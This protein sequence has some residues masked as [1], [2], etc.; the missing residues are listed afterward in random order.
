MDTF[1]DL[2]TLEV[3]RVMKHEA[4]RLRQRHLLM[5]KEEREF[6]STVEGISI[7]GLNRGRVLSLIA[8]ALDENADKLFAYV[9]PPVQNNDS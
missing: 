4:T 9:S 3:A 5:S 7:S 6:H 8:N 2:K 1:S